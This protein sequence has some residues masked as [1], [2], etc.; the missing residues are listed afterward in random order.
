MIPTGFYKKT[1]EKRRVIKI[2]FDAPPTNIQL[3]KC[4]LR[5]DKTF[6]L[7]FSC[8]DSLSDSVFIAMPMFNGGTIIRKLNDGNINLIPNYPGLCYTDGCGKNIPFNYGL[9][10][11]MSAV[12]DSPQ[13]TTYMN[14]KDMRKSYVRG[15]YYS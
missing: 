3:K 13:S 14:L 7:S 5:Y 12:I 1:I 10:L 11:L 15:N 4:R 6:I 9:K 2:T 8:D